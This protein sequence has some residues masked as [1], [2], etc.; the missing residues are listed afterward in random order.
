MS[1]GIHDHHGLARGEQQFGDASRSTA[2]DLL[3]RDGSHVRCGNSPAAL[4]L[5][6]L[7]QIGLRVAKY[8][9]ARERRL[10]RRHQRAFSST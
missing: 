1:S 4:L 3:E 9:V 5:H 7:W 10:R 2:A 8:L 6:P